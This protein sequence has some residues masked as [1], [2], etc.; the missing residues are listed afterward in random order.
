MRTE[1]DNPV[2]ATA[3]THELAI[4]LFDTR[5]PA[6]IC[7]NLQSIFYKALEHP[8]FASPDYRVEMTG[9]I[10]QVTMFL[11]QLGSVTHHDLIKE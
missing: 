10:D 5:H 3:A 9:T 2:T 7:K 1:N 4:Q 8:D 6:E 11:M